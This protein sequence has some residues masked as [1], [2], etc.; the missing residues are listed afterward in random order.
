M[1]I[2]ISE[3]FMKKKYLIGIMTLLLCFTLIGC[4]NK[5]EENKNPDEPTRVDESKFVTNDKTLVYKEGDAYFVYEHEGEKITSYA[6][7]ISYPNH[8]LAQQVYDANKDQKYDT[9]KELYVDGNY[10]VYV[11]AESEYKNY[12]LTSIKELNKE[13]KLVDKVEK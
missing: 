10:L 6:T 3:D 4:T 9:V 13:M 8:E 11:W 7:Y 5:K 1:F 12:T 2:R